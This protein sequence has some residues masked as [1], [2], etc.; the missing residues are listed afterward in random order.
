MPSVIH[1]IDSVT[2]HL[3]PLLTSV[4]WL[5]RLTSGESVLSSWK[6]YPYK[7]IIRQLSNLSR[8]SEQKTPKDIS[9][10]HSST[11]GFVRF[12]IAPRQVNVQ[13]PRIRQLEH[14]SPIPCFVNDHLSLTD[15][16][17]N[18][19][20]PDGI[21]TVCRH[22]RAVDDYRRATVV[23]DRHRAT[24]TAAAGRIP[25]SR[26]DVAVSARRQ[27]GLKRC[28]QRALTVGVECYESGART[29]EGRL[30]PVV[31]APPVAQRSPVGDVPPFDH[32]GDRRPSMLADPV[33]KATVG[34]RINGDVE[35]GAIGV[36]TVV[37][38]SN[39]IVAK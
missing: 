17:G 37:R 23:S 19:P 30:S 38:W 34:R 13:R 16:H 26:R 6:L 1:V 9:L 11:R 5:V 3:K 12:C 18:E 10:K 22:R 35:D 21:S 7:I 24:G 27:S 2:T 28:R 14:P 25:F 39:P 33:A 32:S 15:V 29:R 20:F 31:S 4:H 8:I 36:L